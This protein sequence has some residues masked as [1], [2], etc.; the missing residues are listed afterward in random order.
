MFDMVTNFNR[1]S[2]W[3]ANTVLKEANVKKRAQVIVKL[4]KLAK[5][6]NWIDKIQIF[7]LF[8][9]FDFLKYSY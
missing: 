4:I 6:I 1:T 9:H 8:F 2:H 3:V 5:V 7:F